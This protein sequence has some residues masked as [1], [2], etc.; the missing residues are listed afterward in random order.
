MCAYI[1]LQAGLQICQWHTQV[2]KN[3]T[4]CLFLDSLLTIPKEIQVESS[5]I[6]HLKDRSHCK[7]RQH[8]H[9]MLHDMANCI[10]CVSYK[11][12]I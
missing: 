7:L 2:P 11:E 6:S 4:L 12:T 9:R 5:S 3:E 1:V 10:L 8:I